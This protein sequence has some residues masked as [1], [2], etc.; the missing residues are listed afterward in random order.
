MYLVVFKHGTNWDV[1]AHVFNLKTPTFQ[2]MIVKFIEGIWENL[3]VSLVKE[4]DCS[5]TFA[6][7]IA[8]N[9]KFRHYCMVWY[10]TGVT[11]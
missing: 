7:L 3:H 8:E 9:V 5:Y 1:V 6:D 4:I 2:K 10:A 11:F